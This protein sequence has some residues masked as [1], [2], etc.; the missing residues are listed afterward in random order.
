MPCTVQAN[1]LTHPTNPGD[2]PDCSLAQDRSS[3]IRR[4]GPRTAGPSP[5]HKEPSL[6]WLSKNPRER[7]FYGMAPCLSIVVRRQNRRSSS[8]LRR[9]APFGA[10]ID[11]VTVQSPGDWGPEPWGASLPVLSKRSRKRRPTDQNGP[12]FARRVHH[13]SHGAGDVR[14]VRAALPVAPD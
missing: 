11:L 6:G 9:R 5:G 4:V 3:A 1:I 7:V 8:A 10:V 14:I 12:V 2:P 13:D